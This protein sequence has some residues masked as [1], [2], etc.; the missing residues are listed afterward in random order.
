MIRSSNQPPLKRGITLAYM[1]QLEPKRNS[2]SPRREAQGEEPK[3]EAGQRL[4]VYKIG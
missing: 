1:R 2:W 4:G 3:G